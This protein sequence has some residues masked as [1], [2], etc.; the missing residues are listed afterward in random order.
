LPDHDAVAVD[1]QKYDAD[2]HKLFSEKDYN[3]QFAARRK[4]AIEHIKQ[5]YAKWKKK[6]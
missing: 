3:R 6:K 1:S 4:A 2:K 5:V